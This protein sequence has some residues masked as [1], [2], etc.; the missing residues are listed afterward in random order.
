RCGE[1]VARVGLESRHGWHRNAR[2]VA[3]A[4]DR[5]TRRRPIILERVRQGLAPRNEQDQG[6]GHG[7]NGH[8][9]AQLTTSP[10]MKNRTNAMRYGID[11]Q[12]STKSRLA[13]ESGRAPVAVTSEVRPRVIAR[14]RSASNRIMCR[15]ITMPGAIGTGLPW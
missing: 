14:P 2:R 15:K 1:L 6:R 8:A 11:D 13:R 5:R 9:S 4:D 10:R 3:Q 7:S 12:S